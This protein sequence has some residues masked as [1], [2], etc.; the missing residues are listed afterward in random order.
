MQVKGRGGQEEREDNK[1]THESK[2]R[3]KSE[4]E[5]VEIKKGH[6]E[7]YESRRGQEEVQRCPNSNPM[8]YPYDPHILT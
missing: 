4:N 3:K 6:D 1:T 2:Y 5:E 7:G 8:H